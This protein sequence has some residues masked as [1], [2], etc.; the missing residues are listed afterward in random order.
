MSKGIQEVVAQVTTVVRAV[1]PSIDPGT[2]FMC[3]DDGSAKR[4]RL[5]DWTQHRGFEVDFIDGRLPAPRQDLAPCDRTGHYMTAMLQVRIRY[6]A[7]GPRR[8]LLLAMATDASLV[9]GA[10]LN[11]D[12]W[13]E[14]TTGIYHVEV[15]EPD[16]PEPVYARET[17][18]LIEAA[19]FEADVVALIAPI[20]LRVE[21]EEA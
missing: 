13:V 2:R 14:G 17:E 4:G 6:E 21:Y 9:G 1:V 18:Q 11:P 5:E 19:A 12:N 3:I 15:L 20:H 10:L 8:N 16:E 7:R